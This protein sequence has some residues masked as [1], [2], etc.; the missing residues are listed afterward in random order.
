[1]QVIFIHG[2][3]AAGKYT[4]GT[5]VSN[6]LGLPLF[7]NHLTVDLVSSLFEFGTEAFCQLREAIWLQSFSSASAAGR[8]FV[9]TFHPEA[10]LAPDLV[11]RLQACVEENGGQVQYIELACGDEVLL[12]R[13]GNEDR[14]RFGKLNDPD[15]FIKLQ[16]QGS[17]DSPPLPEPLLRLR[18][19]ALSAEEAASRIVAALQDEAT[20]QSKTRTTRE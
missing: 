2:P 5:L 15:L 11:T 7:H 16:T 9:F 1:M 20:N 6:L 14:G 3:A 8:S 19:D 12:S 13:L 4:I 10:S 17:F 18:T